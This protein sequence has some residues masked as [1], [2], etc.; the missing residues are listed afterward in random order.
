VVHL[1]IEPG[2]PRCIRAGHAVLQS[3]ARAVGEEDPLPGDQGALLPVSDLMVPALTSLGTRAR[4]APCFP[5]R[6]QS[7]PRKPLPRWAPP[8]AA[9]IARSCPL[10]FELG[11][12]QGLGRRRR[13]GVKRRGRRGW[14]HAGARRWDA[15]LRVG[16]PVEPS[17]AGRAVSCGLRG[18][19]ASCS[20]CEPW[21][22]S[23]ASPP[24]TATNEDASRNGEHPS[25]ESHHRHSRGMS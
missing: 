13:R 8:M 12:T 7:A 4:A 14:R 19:P 22:R 6:W 11:V 1:V 23:A 16:D 5:A 3:E 9:R 21:A 24:S 15:R 17:L 25:I 10:G 18:E 2:G 20:S